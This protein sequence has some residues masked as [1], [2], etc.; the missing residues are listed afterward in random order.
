M[1]TDS[2][3]INNTI[4]PRNVAHI[5]MAVET[6]S[7][8]AVYKSIINFNRIVVDIIHRHSNQTI[9]GSRV[10]YSFPRLH[11]DRVSRHTLVV[12]DVVEALRRDRHHAGNDVVANHELVA[13]WESVRGDRLL[14][15][16]EAA[17]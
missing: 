8:N 1:H 17:V 12:G 7:V 13:D 3:T 11:D 2:E 16:T 10:K 9:T 6:W 15:T 14:K 5:Y 4:A